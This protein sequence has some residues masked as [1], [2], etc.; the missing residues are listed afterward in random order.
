MVTCRFSMQQT[1]PECKLGSLIKYGTHPH[2]LSHLTIEH[3]WKQVVHQV[4]WCN[5]N[6]R[7][8]WYT[9][10]FSHRYFSFTRASPPRKEP[11]SKWV[12][13]IRVLYKS[14]SIHVSCIRRENEK[15]IN[16]FRYKV[17][18]EKTSY[19]AHR[20]NLFIFR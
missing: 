15:T 1:C 10:I 17:D 14:T 13:V 12:W 11:I 8:Y 3:R 4:Q 18:W 5:P 6:S 20:G 16:T 19:I 2:N 7:H 9:L